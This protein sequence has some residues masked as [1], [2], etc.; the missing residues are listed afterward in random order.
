MTAL[1]DFARVMD[2]VGVSEYV[3]V[4]QDGHVMVHEAKDYEALGHIV[5][6][7]GVNCD[8][9]KT[10]IPSRFHYFLYNRECGEHLLV[11]PIGSYYLG[12]IQTS[13]VESSHV[14]LSVQDFIHA[15]INPTRQ[16]E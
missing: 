4:R 8:A 2:V 11:F 5:Q 3:L 6:L 13:A 10:G 1:Q 16:P 12:V 7:C 15:L 14:A 9:I